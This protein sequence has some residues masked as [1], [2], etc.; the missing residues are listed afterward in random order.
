MNKIHPDIHSNGTNVLGKKP[1]SHYDFHDLVFTFEGGTD[2][3]LTPAFYT[4]DI[5]DSSECMFLFESNEEDSAQFDDLVTQ[6][7][8]D[9]KSNNG[10]IL[11]LPF[12]RGFMF[13]L[14]I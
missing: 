7:G 3:H 5:P 14:D 12:L 1:C 2:F 10:F 8:L 4:K 13:T 6:D 9:Y 11:G